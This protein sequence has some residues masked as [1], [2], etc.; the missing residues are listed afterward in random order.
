MGV[1]SSRSDAGQP[2]ETAMA[3]PTLKNRKQFDLVYSQGRKRASKTLVVFHLDSALD[4]RVAYVAS[5][6]VGGAVQRNRAKRLLREAV[7]Q[8]QEARPLPLGWFV[9][10]ARAHILQEK[11]A[12]VARDLAAVLEGLA[13]ARSDAVQRPAPGMSGKEAPS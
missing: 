6:I 3:W 2:A 8:V 10:V 1:A 9:L 7:R 11:S 5:R 13:A 4:R 12:T